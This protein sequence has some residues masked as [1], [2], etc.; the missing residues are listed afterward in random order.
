MHI[1]DS[2]MNDIFCSFAFKLEQP[3]VQNAAIGRHSKQASWAQLKFLSTIIAFI[4]QVDS[5]VGVFDRIKVI[6]VFLF[7]T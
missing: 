7:F 3:T 5:N 1:A 6:F 2:W 4:L